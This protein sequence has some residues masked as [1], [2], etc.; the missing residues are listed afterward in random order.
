MC[1]E[2]MFYII[3]KPRHIYKVNSYPAKLKEAIMH[4]PIF[5]LSLLVLGIFY[6]TF[7]LYLVSHICHFIKEKVLNHE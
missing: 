4:Q 5:Y 6:G 1:L 7:L 3:Y 2:N